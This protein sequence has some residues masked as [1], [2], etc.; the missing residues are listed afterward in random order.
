[1]AGRGAS[2]NEARTNTMTVMAVPSLGDRHQPWWQ[3]GHILL[4][5][6]RIGQAYDE[7]IQ[8]EI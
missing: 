6:F 8:I 7:H 3:I 2:S 4:N 1:M 5:T